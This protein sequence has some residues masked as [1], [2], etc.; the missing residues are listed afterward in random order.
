MHS[1][2][3][4][5]LLLVALA[6]PVQAASIWVAWDLDLQ[7]HAPP[8]SF[9]L[10]VT[11][12]TGTPVPAPMVIPWASCTQVPGAQHCAPLGCPPTGVYDF[13]VRAQYAEGLSDPSNTFHCAVVSSVCDCATSTT[14]TSGPAPVSS[15]PPLAQV[16]QIPLP[17]L[18]P[19]LVLLPVGPLPQSLSVPPI[20]PSG[21]G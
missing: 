16:P 12:P 14:P 17:T 21:G 2:N 11:S 20:P 19:G 10:S 6:A 18:P 1:R 15:S 4:W 13:E 7:G 3:A 9:L 5:L 8:T